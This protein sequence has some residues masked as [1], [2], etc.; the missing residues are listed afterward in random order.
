MVSVWICDPWNSY[1]N[2]LVDLCELNRVVEETAED[3]RIER[4]INGPSTSLAILSI[5][6]LNYYQRFRDDQ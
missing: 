2:R 4:E 6:K 1:L 3:L 5:L